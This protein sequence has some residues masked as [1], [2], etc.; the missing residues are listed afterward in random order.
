[1]AAPVILVT[2]S[3][4]SVSRLPA[5]SMVAAPLLGVQLQPKRGVHPRHCRKA[6]GRVGLT[7]RPGAWCGRAV[8]AD[9]ANECEAQSAQVRE[10]WAHH[11]CP[12]LRG[13]EEAK[14]HGDGLVHLAIDG[15]VEVGP[16]VWMYI[17]VMKDVLY[18]P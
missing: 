7:A 18:I 15:E 12:C 8:V 16:I 17:N 10:H 4:G 1:V 9:E 13:D 2:R 11:L 3:A 6:S 14:R 5:V